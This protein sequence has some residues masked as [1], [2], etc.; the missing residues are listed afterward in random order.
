M[1]KVR[2]KRLASQPFYPNTPHRTPKADFKRDDTRES[3]NWH[4][5]TKPFAGTFRQRRG[6]PIGGITP[7]GDPPASSVWLGS[8]KIAVEE[9]GR[10]T[11]CPKTD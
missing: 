8:V 9:A 5:P 3:R 4:L 7:T 11:N 2:S 10:E 6:S 1:R